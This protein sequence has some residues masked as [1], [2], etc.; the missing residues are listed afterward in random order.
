MVDSLEWLYGVNSNTL[1]AR[2]DSLCTGHRNE[3]SLGCR[4][5]QSIHCSLLEAINIL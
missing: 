3:L 2:A 1:I 4:G 5:L